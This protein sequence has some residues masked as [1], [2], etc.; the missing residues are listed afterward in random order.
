MFH[1]LIVFYQNA[2]I[3]CYQNGVRKTDVARL[4]PETLRKMYYLIN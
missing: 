1:P 3:P 4:N 2:T